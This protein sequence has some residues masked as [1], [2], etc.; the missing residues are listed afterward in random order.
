MPEGSERKFAKLDTAAKI[1][2]CLWRLHERKL[3][4]LKVSEC[5][6]NKVLLRHVVAVEKDQELRVGMIQTEVHVSSLGMNVVVTREVDCATL[7][8]HIPDVIPRAVI[9]DEHV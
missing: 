6:V 1:I 7:D 9:Q 8:R 3:W 5:T 4:I 2:E